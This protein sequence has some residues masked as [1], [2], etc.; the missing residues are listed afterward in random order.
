MSLLIR[1]VE[2]LQRFALLNFLKKMCI[3]LFIWE[4]LNWNQTMITAW[5]Q[6]IKQVGKVI[7][8]FP[9]NLVTGERKS[10]SRLL[11]YRRKHNSKSKERE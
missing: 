3:Y 8:S 5:M 6:M 11:L 4:Y 2:N 1:K 10:A 9:G 7:A